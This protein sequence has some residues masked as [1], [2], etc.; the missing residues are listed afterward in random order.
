MGKVTVITSG[1]G[2]TGKSTIAAGLGAALV[3]RGNRVLLIDCDAGM[4]GIDLM[5]GV[6]GELV[7]D[8]ADIINGNCPPA[9]AIY[10]CRTVPELYILPA[11]QNVRDELSPSVM[12]QL[13]KVLARYYD[14]ILIDCPA[15]IGVGFEA[16]VAPAS[17]AILV[18]NA[19]PLSLRGCD[20]VRQKLRKCSVSNIR[21]IINKFNEKKFRKTDA[22][23]D[24]DAVIDESGARLIGI[25]P[26][27]NDASA[28]S[29]KGKPIEGRMKA[30]QAFD[31]IA[32]RFD[33]KYVPLK[34]E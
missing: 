13:T 1:K 7:F 10:P 26:E 33:G 20:K 11:P 21:L 17:R 31:R 8:I 19:E 9:S 27:D 14:H 15:G 12:R 5:L 6:S 18:A 28:A 3:R 16:A 23:P 24:L 4:R 29:Q 34:I 22:F 2:G 30:A 25:V 32:A